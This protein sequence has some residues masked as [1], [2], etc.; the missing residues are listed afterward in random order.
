MAVVA[1]P[2]F[3]PQRLPGGSAVGWWWGQFG[4]GGPWAGQGLGADSSPS[5]SA[6]APQ[7]SRVILDLPAKAPSLDLSPDHLVLPWDAEQLLLF[8]VIITT[9]TPG[10]IHI[11]TVWYQPFPISPPVTAK[12]FDQPQ[13]IK[14]RSSL[15][16]GHHPTGAQHSL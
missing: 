9:T 4:V 3:L 8:P 1:I 10:E 7:H 11:F 16:L 12:H 2:H 15:G 13:L 5:N 6:A 14:L